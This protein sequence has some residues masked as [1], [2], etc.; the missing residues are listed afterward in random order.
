[1]TIRTPP[2]RRSGLGPEAILTLGLLCVPIGVVTWSMPIVLLA[3]PLAGLAAIYAIILVILP[4]APERGWN[5][6]VAFH[7][8]VYIGGVTVAPHHIAGLGVAWG[9]ILAWPL[10][11]GVRAAAQ[12]IDRRQQAGR[13]R[14]EP[15]Q[16]RS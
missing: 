9:A 12:V 10:I 14:A 6:W 16:R 11:W 4:N 7:A 3:A 5:I 13:G 2:Q 8:L 1:M 15:N